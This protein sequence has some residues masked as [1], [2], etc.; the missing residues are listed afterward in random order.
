MTESF[1]LFLWL[2]VAVGL[3]Q[4]GI[5]WGLYVHLS[6]EAFLKYWCL[7]NGYGVAWL[8]ASVVVFRF[9]P[10][11]ALSAHAMHLLLVP[12]MVLQAL[13]AL[14]LA[15]PEFVRWRWR[16][17]A[18]LA[19]VCVALHAFTA[20]M[21]RDIVHLVALLQVE[22]MTVS[23]A[24]VSWFCTEFWRKYPLARTLSGR[25]T[26][27]FLALQSAAFLFAAM[28]AAGFPLLPTPESTVWRVV[29]A[30]LPIGTTA[31]LFLLALDSAAIA[32]RAVRESEERYRMLL[33]T[34]PDAF[35]L[36]DAKGNIS[37][38]NQRAT[39][40]FGYQGGER[41]LIGR[42]ARGLV[43]LA[44]Q[45]EIGQR[46]RAKLRGGVARDFECRLLRRDG[47]EVPGEV[48]ATQV[49]DSNHQ[50]VGWMTLAR[51]IS[52]RRKAEE[53]IRLLAHTVQSASDCILICDTTDHILYANEAFLRTYEY[54]EWEL[55]GRH[56]GFLRAPHNPED[57]LDELLQAT[58]SGGWRGELW[59][60]SKTGRV[61]PVSLTT[62]VVRDEQGNPL[63]TVGVARD[64]TEAKKAET[65][66]RESERRF[67]D[68]LE[69]VQMMAVI[70]GRGGEMAFCNDYLLAATGWTREEMIGQPAYRFIALDQR[71]EVKGIVETALAGGASIP[72]LEASLLTKDGGRRLVQWHNTVLRGADEIPVGFASLGVDVTDHRELQERYLQAQKLESL[73]RL[74]GG[75]AHDFNNLLTVING[76]SS[77]LRSRTEESDPRRKQL[78]EIGKAGERATGLVQQL[79]AFSRRQTTQPQVLRLNTVVADAESMLRR[80]IGEDIELIGK[81]EARP[82]EIAADPSQIHQVLMNLAVNAR[83]AMP[84]G[85]KLNIE[86]GNADVRACDVVQDADASRGAYVQ[87]IVTDTG[88]GMDAETRQ[89]IFEPFFTTKE[90]GKGT[91][92]GL[93]TVYGI[94]R[95]NGGFIRVESSPGEGSSFR[96]FLPQAAVAAV[97][98]QPSS[99]PPVGWSGSETVLLAEDDRNVRE[100]AVEI[101][102]GYGYKVL[103]AASGREALEMVE[104]SGETVDLLLTDVVM[105]GMN[106]K[107]LAERLTASRP[108]LKVILMSG[109]ADEAIGHRGAHEAGWAYLP[110]PFPPQ[111]LVTKVREVLAMPATLRTILVVDDEEAVRGLLQDMLGD[112]YRVLVAADGREALE[113]IEGEPN[114]DLVI[115]DLVMPNLEGIETIQAIRKLRPGLKIVAMSGAFG[116]HFLKSAKV[117]GADAA[118]M[119]PIQVDT[120]R[121]TLS[122][123]LK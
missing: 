58:L 29:G 62:S 121:K 75:V 26:T 41:E 114:L 56:I 94:V 95:Q 112:R 35:I 117:L 5:L 68:L 87:L 22:R 11:T 20:F 67:R 98:N 54:E 113:T 27:L 33:R 104:T 81:L 109:Y 71:P 123:L 3:L 38:C 47:S 17:V 15:S 30:L 116:G 1:L 118:L 77:L 86:T 28:A 16:R 101:L 91:G 76:Y 9:A 25:I 18:G 80:L 72:V 23:A 122:E 97:S 19:L 63:A 89:H 40:L 105:P 36:T 120:L 46:L 32:N 4:S 59:N 119:K 90:L 65:A 108:G 70:M 42:P 45:A 78:D 61:F 69:N 111:A 107:T 13:A 10:S 31:G 100:L 93:A 43:A 88:S 51:D 8:A 14:S 82:D 39:E 110:K 2:Q 53:R 7:A 12:A 92:L 66:L 48:S 49:L 44:E 24:V 34:S 57:V 106:G 96:V 74:A 60:R 50:T 83:D 85:G 115:T 55:L 21:A 73:G 37:M 64:E 79:L 6:R 102:R 99:A 52:E 84:H 103:A